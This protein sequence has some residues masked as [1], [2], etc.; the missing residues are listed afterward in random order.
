MH[1]INDTG[2]TDI[3]MLCWLAD[4]VLTKS[5]VQYTDFRHLTKSFQKLKADTKR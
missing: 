1:Q 4:A 5:L 2:S 3:I